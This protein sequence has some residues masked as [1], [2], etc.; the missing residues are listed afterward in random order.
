MATFQGMS[1]ADKLNDIEILNRALFFELRGI[2]AYRVAGD[3]LTASQVGKAVLELASQNRADHEKHQNLLGDAIQDLG[4]SASADLWVYASN[5]TTLQNS[6]LVHPSS[7]R[8]GYHIKGEPL[9]LKEKSEPVSSAVSFADTLMPLEVLYLPLMPFGGGARLEGA[10][11]A[12]LARLRIDLAGIQ[13]V[14]A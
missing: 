11:V 6:Y 1:D 2:W 4:A 12:A 8:M 13:P 3:K 7:D 5:G 10:E 9:K 14:F